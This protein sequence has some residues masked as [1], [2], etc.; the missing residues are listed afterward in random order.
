MTVAS[1]TYRWVAPASVA[2]LGACIG[3][4][5]GL[6]PQLAIAG[7]IAIGFMLLVF[8]NL[9][10]GLVIFTFL[11]FLAVVP[12]A[13]GPA[14]SFLK[15]AGLL[16]AL[17]WLSL[18]AWRGEAPRA[19]FLSAYPGLTYTVLAFL[20]WVVISQVWAEQPSETL[21]SFTRYG[22]NAVLFLIVFSAVQKGRDAIDV[23][24]AFVAGAV[25]AALYGLVTAAPDPA[26]ADRLSGSIGNPNELAAVLVVGA[27]LAMGLAV[28][29]RRSPILR[30][31]ATVGAGF[32]VVAILFTLS[33][34]GLVAM[35][36]ALVAS[37]VLAGRWRPQAAVIALIVAFVGFGYFTAV[38][39]PE[40]RQR[41]SDA[42][43]GT[44]RL[45][46]WTVGR[47]MAAAH[48]INGVGAGN[49]SNTS[50]QFLL[51]PG[52]LTNT[53]FII[54][55][56][57]NAH[58]TYLEILAEMGVVGLGLWVAILLLCVRCGWRAIRN[59]TASGNFRMEILSRAVLIALIGLLAADFFN[60]LEFDKTLWL[61][62]GLCPALQAI[63]QT[64]TEPA[65]SPAPSPVGAFEI[66]PS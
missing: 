36:F 14:L 65:P 41:I 22:L 34:T 42:G 50:R 43:N 12:T 20:G 1:G 47:R 2:T 8:V 10:A 16:L 19:N 52:G 28:G 38:A 61:L 45:D 17:S 64:E 51:Q 4:L 60:S 30:L 59:F 23:V 44:G 27:A 15:V 39:S 63:S 66:A 48:P 58:N 37:L 56:P 54:D 49:F 6:Q 33:R 21:L 35:G 3:L 29:A 32:C 7:S 11:S 62:L 13:G 31:A 53:E 18:I 5:A 55:T 25:I 24:M 26:E 40:A 9:T 46:I 57:K